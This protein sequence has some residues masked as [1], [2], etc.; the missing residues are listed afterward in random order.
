MVPDHQVGQGGI[1]T[2]D[3]GGHLVGRGLHS[4]VDPSTS[5]SSSVTVPPGRSSLTP[6][7]LQ[8]V[9]LMLISLRRCRADNI[10]Q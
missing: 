7:S 10:R 1:E 9:S 6:T 4:R 2:R 8:F 3:R 5:A